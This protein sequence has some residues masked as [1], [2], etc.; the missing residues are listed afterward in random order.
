[1][2]VE[3]ET[4]PEAVPVL[5]SRSATEQLPESMHGTLLRVPGHGCYLLDCGENTLGQLKRV[6]DPDEHVVHGRQQ[7]PPRTEGQDDEE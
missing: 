2:I 3:P 6:L 1:M 4:E 7:W 5:L